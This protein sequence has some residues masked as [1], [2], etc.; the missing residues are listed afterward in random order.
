MEKQKRCNERII[1]ID[2]LRIVAMLGV[3]SIH[4][5][6][7]FSWDDLPDFDRKV[8]EITGLPLNACVPLFFMMSG[9]LMLEKKM[10]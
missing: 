4:V 3:V 5:C 6:S 7:S 10:I 1:W 8:I 2:L 9:M